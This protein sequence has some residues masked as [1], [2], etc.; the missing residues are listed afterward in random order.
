MADRTGTLWEHLDTRASCCHGF[1]AIASEYLF[2]DVLG[3]RRIDR[4]S[5]TVVVEP[6]PDVP[7]DWCEGDV[8]LSSSEKMSVKWRKVGASVLVDVELPCGWSR[9]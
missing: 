6:S 2:R 3:V 1:A 7:L 5:K 9:K 4:M 8:P